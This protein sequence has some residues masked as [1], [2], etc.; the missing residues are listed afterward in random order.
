M[1]SPLFQSVHLQLLQWYHSLFSSLIPMSPAVSSR[2]YLVA[3]CMWYCAQDGDCHIL[4]CRYNAFGWCSI[5]W[6]TIISLSLEIESSLIYEHAI[7]DKV[8]VWH[9]F[10]FL[11]LFLWQLEY[12]ITIPCS[13]RFS[14]FFRVSLHL[15]TRCLCKAEMDIDNPG[16]ASQRFCLISERIAA[17][18][19]A[20]YS[21]KNWEWTS[22]N[23]ALRPT[24]SF[25]MLTSKRLSS[26]SLY[27]LMQ[28]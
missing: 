19:L 6:A 4:R 7:S 22:V 17:G 16:S 23:L 14:R 21:I 2:I 1:F 8:H 11:N 15:R 9:S 28:C 5:S 18:Y 10:P 3:P 26:S 25:L 12:S 20:I 13:R 27:F 24:P